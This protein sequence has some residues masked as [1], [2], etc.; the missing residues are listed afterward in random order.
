MKIVCFYEAYESLAFERF[1]SIFRK[2]GIDHD[3]VMDRGLF[4]DHSIKLPFSDF[5]GTDHTTLAHRILAGDPDYVLFSVFTDNIVKI[6]KISEKIKQKA[7]HVKIIAGGPHVTTMYRKLLQ[8]TLFDIVVRGAGEDFIKCLCE[9]R[10]YQGKGACYKSGDKIIENPFSLVPD[11]EFIDLKE[12]KELFL[13]K[14]PWNREYIHTISSFGCYFKCSYC[15]HSIFKS[16]CSVVRKDIDIFISQLADLKN[17]GMRKVIFHDDLFISDKEHILRFLRQYKEKIDLPFM[18]IV[19]P[20]FL[21]EEICLMLKKAGCV[22]AEIGS[23]VL[24]DTLR[25]KYLNRSDHTEDV[26]NA[27]RLL[28]KTG[29]PFTVDHIFG[30]PDETLSIHERSIL[31]YIRFNPSRIHFCY[32]TIYPKS[33]INDILLEK[34]LI[35]SRK[36]SDCEKGIVDNVNMGGSTEVDINLKK[37][38]IIGHLS[39]LLPE[40]FIR[41][42]IKTGLYLYIPAS[43]ALWS[44]YLFYSLTALIKRNEF[45]ID[46]QLKRYLSSLINIRTILFK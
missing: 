28:D 16:R 25:K 35:D 20:A 30:I 19:Y 7:P 17:R 36:I 14:M 43:A 40:F 9:G 46:L 37:L 22:N 23:Q 21:N 13:E 26:I 27:M 33:K 29:V 45:N 42:L 8:S 2:Y 44:K 5:G 18:C 3:L 15:Y 32:M 6:M 41:F 24:S 39:A 34:G 4:T 1:F 12:D 11:D 31:T 10:P 38:E